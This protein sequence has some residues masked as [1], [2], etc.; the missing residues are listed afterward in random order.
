MFFSNEL[1]FLVHTLVCAGGVVLCAYIGRSL[2]IAYLCL[3][4][5]LANLFVLKTMTLFGLTATCSDMYMVAIVLGLN[6]LQEWWGK[7]TAQKAIYY[8]FGTLVA[9]TSFCLLHLSYVPAPTDTHA[10]FYQELLEHMPRITAASLIA[11]FI[12]LSCDRALY[13]LLR[14]NFAWTVSKAST[15]SMLISQTCDTLLFSFLALYGTVSGIWTIIIV[16]LCIKGSAIGLMAPF[17][18]LIS[19][20]ADRKKSA[21][22]LE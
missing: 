16:S 13:T 17:T 20:L 7:E 14:N 1:I 10:F 9:Y 18:K 8:G 19:V 4:G 22:L 3:L 2:L 21:T 6:I 11:Y 5:V 15:S 12:S